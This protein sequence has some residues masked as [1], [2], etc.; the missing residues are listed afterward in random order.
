M[1]QHRG[2]S[3]VSR[4][5]RLMTA[6]WTAPGRRAWR[7]VGAAAQIYQGLCEDAGWP[8]RARRGHP[9]AELRKSK[10]WCP[11]AELS[12]V[13]RLN[14]LGQGPSGQRGRTDEEANI[15]ADGHGC[16]TSG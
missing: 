4:E 5:Q 11:L 13:I 7:R 8:G 10:T 6:G 16:N 14:G 3:P 1:S 9:T 12:A 15:P 2:P